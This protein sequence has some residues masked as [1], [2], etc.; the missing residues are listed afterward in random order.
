MLKIILVLVKI[1]VLVGKKGI[2][3]LS[4]WTASLRYQLLHRYDVS[5]WSVFSTYQWE[6]TK[7]SQIE[8]FHSRT[9][10]DVV[11]TPQHEPRRRPI[12]DLI[13]TS[14]RR[15]CGVG[16]YS[17]PH[18]LFFSTWETSVAGLHASN[19]ARWVASKKYDYQSSKFCLWLILK[20]GI[21]SNKHPRQLLNFGTARCGAY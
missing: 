17:K 1:Y 4:R 15:A 20:Y 14:L 10:C 8:P 11:M 21:S 6:V 16:V 5:N 18:R 19:W 7:T 13:E 2:R 3:K 9:C 12:W